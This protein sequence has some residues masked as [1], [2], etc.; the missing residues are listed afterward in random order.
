[1]IVAGGGVAA[2]ETTLALSELAPEQTDVS[3][4]APNEDFAYRPLSV[5]EPFAYGTARR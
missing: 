2:L 1:V 5:R 3:V 4:I